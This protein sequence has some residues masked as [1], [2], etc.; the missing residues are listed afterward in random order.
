MSESVSFEEYLSRYGTLT[1]TNKGVSMEP[2][3]H[4]GRDLFTVVKKGPERCRA[5]DVVLFRRG[6]D[7]VLHRIVEVLPEGYVCLGDNSVYPERG[8][9]DEDILGVLTGFVRKGKEHSV[10]EGP[11]RA[12]SALMLNARG[13]RVLC[14]RA[15]MKGKR[16]LTR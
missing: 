3:L 10:T 14:T 12:Y 7:Y 5:G 9:T 11:Y 15:L 13:L 16:L 1:Y 2:L 6:K 8:V 4:Q